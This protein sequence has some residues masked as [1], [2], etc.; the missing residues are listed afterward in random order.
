[1]AY[2]NVTQIYYDKFGRA[3]DASGLDYWTKQ[4]ESGASLD[5]IAASFD[6]SEEAQSHAKVKAAVEAGGD[7]YNPSDGWGEVLHSGAVT[8][9]EAVAAINSDNAAKAAASTAST[10]TANT[11]TA[12][13]ST[14]N[15]STAS[16]STANTNTANTST[17]STAPLPFSVSN[18]I[19]SGQSTEDFIDDLYTNVLGRTDEETAE[20]L[21]GRT[22]HANVIQDL[23]DVHGLSQQE[24]FE[25]TFHNFNI[26][27]EK[28][29]SNAML[30][31]A[32]GMGG[33]DGGTTIGAAMHHEFEKDPSNVETAGG[34]TN[35]FGGPVLDS[36]TKANE[37][38]SEAN[39][40]TAASVRAQNDELL[41]TLNPK[42]YEKKNYER[43]T[44]KYED[45]FGRGIDQGGLDH[46]QK[47]LMG[48]ATWDEV[49]ANIESSL[50]DESVVAKK[51]NN[52]N[53]NFAV[54]DAT[55]V[56]DKGYIPLPGAGDTLQ[57]G[58]SAADYKQRWDT[59]Y[60]QY[61]DD[62][63]K[64]IEGSY[65]PTNQNTGTL[66]A[67]QTTQLKDKFKA[68]AGRDITDAELSAW[69]THIGDNVDTFN[70]ALNTI[71]NYNYTESED[72][73]QEI[74]DLFETESGFTIDDNIKSQLQGAFANGQI[75]NIGQMKNS[76]TKMG[77]IA[78]Q[79]KK[80]YTHYGQQDFDVN[81]LI[82]WT[83]AAA[84][85]DTD[86]SSMTKSIKTFDFDEPSLADTTT[87]LKNTIKQYSG[88]DA[89]QSTIDNYLSALGFTVN[90]QPGKRAG[91]SGFLPNLGMFTDAIS[92]YD[93][94]N[95]VT[96]TCAA[97]EELQNGVCVKKTTCPAGETLVNGVCTPTNTTTECQTGYSKNANGVCV[98]DTTTGGGANCPAGQTKNAAGVC[99][100]D[101]TTTETTACPAGQTRNAAGVC[102][103]DSTGG[104][105]T[106]TTGGTQAT[107][108]GAAA[109]NAKG[110]GYYWTGSQ[111]ISIDT[112]DETTNTTNHELDAA[113]DQITS[114]QNKNKELT[115]LYDA[116]LDDQK[117]AAEKQAASEI[118]NT[119]WEGKYK[120]MK[121]DYEDA[122]LAK[123]E[124]ERVTAGPGRSRLTR[125]GTKGNRF[126]IDPVN[127][128]AGSFQSIKGDE[129]VAAPQMSANYSDARKRA[130]SRRG[131][132]AGAAVNS[133]YYADR[134][135]YG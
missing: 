81:N 73:M 72:Q 96:T 116:A 106:S 77:D 112:E 129:P 103:A 46:W 111:C 4:A 113:R 12:N 37:K 53:Q 115:G 122:I 130:L 40:A 42:A 108:D 95:A 54:G 88:A 135:A 49:V 76:L 28:Q 68:S 107:G 99:V 48:G 5:A 87:Y 43:L 89:D 124:I 67:D 75:N 56:D 52:F 79:A 104:T 13:T 92:N 126:D 8:A 134:N 119:D 71:S 59:S 1:M 10:S 101:T 38:T 29:I 32:S 69:G 120:G 121:Q 14:A 27:A 6:V 39:K 98:P 33:E 51:T 18:S 105:D 11:S 31:G 26:S 70:N 133:G 74:Y 20:D 47:D 22:Y 86:L 58:E 97:D 117:T 80:L 15:T 34:F 41:R 25:K 132:A 125:G 93:F 55:N 127:L 60:G 36:D 64:Y 83:K 30:G 109:C 65:T 110:A 62:D 91:D 17:S 63:G 85:G 82:N 78:D 45:W 102:V 9:D 66:T 61:Y 114:L 16:T 84:A 131:Q 2:S 50:Q 24:A 35:I 123:E 57:V 21:E 94:G 118:L 19:A 7:T 3:P 128:A 44:E 90:G 23:Q 100:A